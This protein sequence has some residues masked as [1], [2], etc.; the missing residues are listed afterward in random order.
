ME[1]AWFVYGSY[2]TSAVHRPLG[3]L[4]LA[5]SGRESACHGKETYLGEREIRGCHYLDAAVTT[6]LIQLGDAGFRLTSK[7]SA[8]PSEGAGG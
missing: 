2:A 3:N 4:L 7:S 1:R 6:S 8:A 5:R